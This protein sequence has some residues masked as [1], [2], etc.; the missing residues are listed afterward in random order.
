MKG[1]SGVV[2]Y[3]LCCDAHKLVKL[4]EIYSS[5][6]LL[7]SDKGKGKNGDSQEVIQACDFEGQCHGTNYCGF[8][9]V[10]LS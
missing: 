8:R 7:P 6:S 3:H 5:F 2:S 4:F 1:P 10:S 9:G